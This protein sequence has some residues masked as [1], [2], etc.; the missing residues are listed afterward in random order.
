MHHDGDHYAVSRS[1]C[2]PPQAVQTTDMID[3]T[4]A[5]VEEA[6]CTLH[7]VALYTP[8]LTSCQL[9][10]LSGARVFLKCKNFQRVGVVLTGG[11]VEWVRPW[12]RLDRTE[13]MQREATGWLA[14]HVCEGL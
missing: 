6:V 4:C 5:P 3:V 10:A 14:S 12:L 1:E 7:G 2:I 11:N 9:D 8:V 13:T